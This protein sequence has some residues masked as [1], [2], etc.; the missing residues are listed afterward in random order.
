VIIVAG[1]VD[2]APEERST[3]LDLAE[4]AIK[5]CRAEEGCLEYSFNEDRLDPGRV[6]VLEIW[7]GEESLRRHIESVD[8]G[9]GPPH[10]V[11]ILSEL[12]VRYDV[13][14]S[15]DLVRR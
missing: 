9:G 3:F 10:S 5:R 8:A 12:L 11:E 14:A 15:T 2:F 7:D 6:R 1:Y 4:D 13:S